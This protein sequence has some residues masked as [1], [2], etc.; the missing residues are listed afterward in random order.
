MITQCGRV[1]A[2]LLS[3]ENCRA[4]VRRHELLRR[5]ATADREVVEG[6]GYDS[7]SGP[8]SGERGAGGS[9]RDKWPEEHNSIW[10]DQKRALRGA[11]D[12]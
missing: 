9:G 7:T 6:T 11:Y 3:I 4:A 10:H 1:T 12:A 8:G 5:I 2:V